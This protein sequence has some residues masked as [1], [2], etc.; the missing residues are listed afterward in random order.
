MRACICIR[1]HTPLT[2]ALLCP[3]A[4]TGMLYNSLRRTPSL[5]LGIERECVVTTS[6]NCSLSFAGHRKLGH[7]FVSR[8]I[9]AHGLEMLEPSDGDRCHGE[10]TLAARPYVDYHATH[11]IFFQEVSK[12]FFFFL[13]FVQKKNRDG[14]A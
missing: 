5:G 7:R 13:S 11:S 4:L 3:L 2:G 9:D 12:F 10:V 1:V 8:R 6:S 14:E